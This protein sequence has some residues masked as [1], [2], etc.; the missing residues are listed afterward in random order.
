[1]HWFRNWCKVKSELKFLSANLNLERIQKESIDWDWELSKDLKMLPKNWVLNPDKL[2]TI[3]Q[4]AGICLT[5]RQD[6]VSSLCYGI[7]HTPIEIGFWQE[8]KIPKLLGFYLCLLG[9]CFRNGRGTSNLRVVAIVL[10]PN[11]WAFQGRYLS[12]LLGWKGIRE[13]MNWSTHNLK[14][15]AILSRLF[16]EYS[17]YL[18]PS[19]S[20]D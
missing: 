6:I 14:W 18:F 15:K 19:V 8:K 17:I 9:F 12:A 5:K 4:K 1:M 10:A 2:P 20:T 7:S 13:I 3:S 16:I 11:R